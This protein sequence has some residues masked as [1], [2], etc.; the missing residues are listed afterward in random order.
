MTI[1][2]LTFGVGLDPDL[3]GAL[4]RSTLF[5]GGFPE[6][7]FDALPDILLG[8]ILRDCLDIRVRENAPT[9]QALCPNITVGVRVNPDILA[10]TVWAFAADFCSH[11]T[12]Q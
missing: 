11:G 8:R 1:I 7:V 6:D 9:S 5:E 12:L 4:I 10:S 3:A 2:A